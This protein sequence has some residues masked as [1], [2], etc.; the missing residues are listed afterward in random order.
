MSRPL[1]RERARRIDAKLCGLGWQAVSPAA[2]L[3]WNSRIPFPRNDG[4]AWAG[5]GFGMSASA[6]V[7]VQ[8]GRFRAQLIPQIWYAENRPFPILA[9][10]ARDLSG[11]VNPFHSGGGSMADLPLRF[12]DRSLL[13]ADFGQSVVEVDAGL[14]TIGAGAESQWWGPGLRNALIMSNHAAG[15]PGAYVRTTRPVRTPLGQ[16]EA[17]WMVGGLTESPFFDTDGRNN[18]RSFSGLVVVLAPAFDTTFSIGGGRVVYAAIP[19]AGA[20]PARFLDA[21]ARWGEGLDV[22]AATFGRAAD[23]FTTLFT[24]WVLPQSGLELYLDWARVIL[25]KSVRSLLVAPQLSQGYTFGS[26]WVSNPSAADLR[27]RFQMEFTMLEQQ[28]VTRAE[29]PPTFFVS[30]VVAQGYTQRGQVVGAAIGPGASSQWLALDRMTR[31][32]RAGLFIERV[33]WETD[34]FYFRRTGFDKFAH[35]VSLIGGVR[36]ARRAGP[37]DATLEI[38]SEKRMNYLFQ[39]ARNG[40][41]EDEVFDIRNVSF[42]LG[43]TPR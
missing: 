41:G 17:R 38:Q 13:V 4:G 19:G 37:F 6:G 11:F 16:A 2:D 14:V 26:Q 27:W 35:D 8:C 28:L 20:L 31:G 33:R 10:D 5:R 30:P 39:N 34:A 15:I 9:A 40:F 12:G 7:R 22:R 43:V 24:R 1:A 42:R 18:L 36:G 3:T 32:G 25:P 23:Q 21:V 29:Q